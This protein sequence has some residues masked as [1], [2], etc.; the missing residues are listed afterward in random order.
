MSHPTDR[1]NNLDEVPPIELP[2]DDAPAQSND[3]SA[4][5]R[6][7]TWRSLVFMTST[8]VF[9]IKKA[10]QLGA[11]DYTTLEARRTAV[12]VELELN[13]SLAPDV[14]IRLVPVTREP[15]GARWIGGRGEVVDWALHMKRLPDRDRADLRVEHDRLG[16][17]EICAI[18]HRV[19]AFHEVAP[20]VEGDSRAMLGEAIEF[21]PPPPESKVTVNLDPEPAI[22]AARWQ[23]TFLSEHIALF[24]QRAASGCLRDGHGD[25]GLEHVFV[26]D[27]GNA[28]I[29]NRLEFD[30]RLRKLD[31]CADIAS[32]STDLA[33]AGRADLAERFLAHY[34]AEANDFD[35]YPL[36]DFYAS[37][38]ASL[39]GKLEWFYADHFANDPLGAERRRERAERCF[40]LAAS[41]KWRP[42]LPP[43]VVAVGGLVASG[44]ST[45]AKHLG[46]E[47][48]APVISSDR[49]RVTSGSPSTRSHAR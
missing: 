28:Q 16:N 19:A 20:R 5:Q 23:R 8:D 12:E 2:E 40:K 17:D 13:Q 30:P 33:T 1:R 35:L 22:E 29:I 42:L 41:A 45:V 26:D 10:V 6:I 4:L 38:R 37:L 43:V 44:K 14:Y 15:Q 48:G 24:E 46:R 31:T 11:L 7:E 25:L 21:E 27:D 39:R 49:A 18:A 9:K 34:A 36:I 32:F 3:G 47:I